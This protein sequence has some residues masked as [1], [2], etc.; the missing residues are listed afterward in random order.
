M[1]GSMNEREDIL[2]S[3][4]LINFIVTGR[5]KRKATTRTQKAKAKGVEITS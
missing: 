5:V 4:T 3:N 1:L 2:L